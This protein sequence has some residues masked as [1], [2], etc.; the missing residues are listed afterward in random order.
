MYIRVPKLDNLLFQFF[1]R[2]MGREKYLKSF[3]LFFHF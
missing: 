3:A 1:V 2:N